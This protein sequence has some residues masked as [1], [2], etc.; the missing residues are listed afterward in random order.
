[1]ISEVEIEKIWL[2]MK[3]KNITLPTRS[4][5][6]YYEK[7]FKKDI[8]ELKLKKYYENLIQTE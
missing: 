8:N 2:E 1:M 5:K 6:N 7:L 3:N 4:F